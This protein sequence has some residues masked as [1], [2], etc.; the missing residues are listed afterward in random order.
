MKVIRASVMGYCMGVRQAVNTAYKEL[1]ERKY[2]RVYTLGPLIHNPY[3]LEDLRSRGAE[4]LDEKNLPEN[5]QGAVVII[6]AHGITPDLEAKLSNRGALLIDA[7]C[8]RVKAN[9]KKAESLTKSGYTI[10]LAGDKNH[11]EI[12]GIQGYA[13]SCFVVSD[14]I[15]AL[16]SAEKLFK[17]SPDSKTALLGQTTISSEEYGL[18]GDAVRRYFPCL[19]VTDSICKATKDRQNALKELCKNV[20]AV[21]IVGGRESANTQRLLAIARSES[22]LAWL[23]ENEN[24]IPQDVYSYS[25]IGLCAGASTPDDLIDKTEAYIAGYISRFIQN[26]D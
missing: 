12:I 16:E 2:E 6:R 22:K 1:K 3:V 19:E 18:I 11:A 25:T 7:T 14:V 8:S 10:F 5:L 21:I 24:D 9:Q 23:A 17:Q 26:Y 13:P 20:D 4:I 15:S